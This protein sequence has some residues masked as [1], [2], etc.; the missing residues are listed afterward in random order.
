M[1]SCLCSQST[2][3]NF[4]GNSGNTRRWLREWGGMLANQLAN[5]CTIYCSYCQLIATFPKLSIAQLLF[6]FFFVVVFFF[7]YKEESNSHDPRLF[8]VIKLH[9]LLLFWPWDPLWQKCHTF[10]NSPLLCLSP[11]PHPLQCT[12]FPSGPFSFHPPDAL[13]LPHLPS[14]VLQ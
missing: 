2:G 11:S 5:H 6:F 1:V 4:Q 13:T 8:Y 3:Y 10:H 7:F 9:P 12:F 14:S